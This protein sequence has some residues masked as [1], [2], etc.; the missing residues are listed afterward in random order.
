MSKTAPSGPAP[1]A[2][3]RRGQIAVMM[4]IAFP[5]LLGGVGIGID[6]GFGYAHRRQ[7]ENAADAAAMAGAQA[8][9]AYYSYCANT[10]LW[11]V[12]P[13]T[14][15]G[16]LLPA[17]AALPTAQ[18]PVQY[19]DAMIMQDITRAAAASIPPYPSPTSNPSWPTG[20]GNT[21][22][23]YYMLTTQATPPVITQGAQVG[24]GGPPA[25][26]AGV[27]VE[28]HMEYPT[29][30]ARVL[31]T[32]CQ[33]LGVWASA[34]GMLSPLAAPGPDG[35]G[36]FIVCGGSPG[37]DGAYVDDDRVGGQ[38]PIDPSDN[39]DVLLTGSPPQVNYAAFQGKKYVVQWEQ[40]RNNNGSCDTSSS[41]F[42]G[43]NTDDD[44]SPPG[45]VPCSQTFQNGTR[46]GPTRN[47]VS[48]LP[49]CSGTTMD[50]CVALLPIANLCGTSACN[51]VA[52]AP[53]LLKTNGTPTGCNASNCHTGTLLGAA[54]VQ[55]TAGTGPFN[56]NNPGSFTTGLSP[57][58]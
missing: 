46:S 22:T 24:S 4:A 57:D 30:F 44:C 33:K 54:S 52:F 10:V 45:V 14:C 53:F 8:L 25:T 41:D 1:A 38:L 55:G 50:N 36:P 7:M 49:A 17:I 56:T 13:G 23:A 16:G 58:S 47:R 5:V 42:K 35:G 51:V 26:A 20:T 11:S 9:G 31:G 19:T 21:L 2:G 34:R 28:V 39:H 32:C 12:T 40:L 15:G 6:L 37:G 48:G 27:R 43:N 29:L 18:Q 3:R